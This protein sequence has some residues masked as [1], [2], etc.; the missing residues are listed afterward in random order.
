MRPK[1]FLQ[2]LPLSGPQFIFDDP[3]DPEVP[4]RVHAFPQ[5]LVVVCLHQA[6]NL[7]LN[8]AQNDQPSQQANRQQDYKLNAGN[9][10]ECP[11]LITI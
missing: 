5:I 6:H 10:D 11:K 4:N 1:W 8:H 2:G 9:Q 3:L 7:L